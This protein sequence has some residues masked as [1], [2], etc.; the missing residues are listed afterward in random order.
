MKSKLIMAA[1]LSTISL[2]TSAFAD[3]L[4][5]TMSNDGGF[6][7]LLSAIKSAGIEN[8][9]KV[10]GPLTVFA[11]TDLAFAA[12]PKAKLD[13]LLADKAALKKMINLHMVN[14]KVTKAD[15]D[16]GKIKTIEG[17]DVT[18]SVAGG[19]KINGIPTVGQGIN[20]D[21]GVIHALTG[22]MIPK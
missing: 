14:G 16:A 21:N 5:E 20:A 7:T 2:S 12:M 8:E 17:E 11:P 15:V 4:M 1:L 10:N 22:V 9:F 18:L 6:K 19:V 13:Q 3:D